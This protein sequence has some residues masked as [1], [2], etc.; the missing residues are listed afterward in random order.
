VSHFHILRQRP[1]TRQLAAL[2]AMLGL[3]ATAGRAAA[4]QADAALGRTILADT[5]L[6]L[7]LDRARTLLKSGFNAGSG[8]GEVW[9][10]DFNT[11]IELALTVNDPA[12]IRARTIASIRPVSARLPL[13]RLT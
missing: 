2:A 11:F 13:A 4:P 12:T 9:I 5:S 3:L 10:R 8:Y 7:A 1:R 6:D